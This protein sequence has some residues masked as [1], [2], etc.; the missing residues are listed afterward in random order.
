MQGAPQ[1]AMVGWS[2]GF[3]SLSVIPV[4]VMAALNSAHPTFMVIKAG[5]KISLQKIRVISEYS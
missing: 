1:Q 4:Q 5:N 2:I 3:K